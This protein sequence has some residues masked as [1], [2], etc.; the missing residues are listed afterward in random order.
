M[1]CNGKI[2]VADGMLLPAEHPLA[3]NHYFLTHGANVGVFHS[4]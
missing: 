1:K 4:N 3:I 2:R